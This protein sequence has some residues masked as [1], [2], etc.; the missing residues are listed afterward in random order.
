MPV[1]IQSYSLKIEEN[2]SME[3]DQYL[4]TESNNSRDF[5]LWELPMYSSHF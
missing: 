1:Y 4:G 3:F 5:L 2:N